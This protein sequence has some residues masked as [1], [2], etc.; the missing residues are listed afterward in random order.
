MM[1]FSFPAGIW[2]WTMWCS[3]RK[4]TSRLP[5]LACAR[6]ACTVTINSPRRSAAHPTTLLP[7]QDFLLPAETFSFKLI[8]PLFWN[9]QIILYQPYG[10]SVDWWAYGVLLYEMLAGQ[11]FSSFSFSS[12]FWMPCW[13]KFLLFLPFP[14]LRSTGKTRKS[15]LPR[16]RSTPWRTPKFYRKRPY[17]SAKEYVEKK[18]SNF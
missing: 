2:N 17:P 4:A 11:V 10:K 13:H 3:T 8:F 14:S 12:F 18:F 9:P 16:L 6:R 5:T 1:V 15:Y 7:R